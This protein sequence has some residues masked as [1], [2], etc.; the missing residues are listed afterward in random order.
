LVEHT[1]NTSDQE[2]PA[3]LL[4]KYQYNVEDKGYL[5][6]LTDELFEEQVENMKS[7]LNRDL[8]GKFCSK[9]QFNTSILQVLSI[10]KS[11]VVL[12]T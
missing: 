2:V 9:S 11:A 3:Y 7:L 12:P 4:I 6:V 5:V 1:I 8:L 10:I